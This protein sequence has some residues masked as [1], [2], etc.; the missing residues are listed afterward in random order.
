[1]AHQRFAY[2]SLGDVRS[3]A[4]QLGEDLPLSEQTDI[5]FQPLPLK[6]GITLKNRIALQPMEGSDGTADGAPGPLTER[7]YHRFAVGGAGLIWFEA[8]ATAPEVRASPHQLYLTEQNLSHFQRLV[9]QIKEIGLKENGFAPVVIMQA[10]HS[11]RYSK[12]EGVPAPIIAYNN[13][14]FEKD[15]PIDASRIVTDDALSAYAARYE[16]TARLCREAGFDGIDVKCCHRY[17]ANELLSAYQRPG[18]YG[19]S[20]ENRTRF[21]RECYQAAAA[22][23]GPGFLKTSRLNVY[24]GYPYPY[25]FGVS[26]EGGVA[27]V[28]EEGI[29]LGRLLQ[30]AFDIPLLNVTIG[31]PY[32]NPHVNRPYDSG[33]YV[34]P[35][36]PFTGLAR[37]MS[38][39][40]QMQAALDIPVVGSAFSYLR[41]FAPNLAAGMVEG[42]HAAVAGFGRMAFADPDFPKQLEDEGSIPAGA[43]CVT[44]GRCA[45]LLRAGGPSG[46][47][48]R[49]EAYRTT[50]TKE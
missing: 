16:Q 24:D 43:V 11:G 49:D 33:A 30:E 37:M 25:G 8:V 28:L 13:P 48:V 39:V 12:P 22:G 29:A 7:R 34:P 14:L 21:L 2:K 19:G 20:F 23:A 17:M 5:L 47:V 42:G 18:R 9:A 45:A 36:H 31:N 40:G 27:P 1:M 3:T 32:T 41:Q 26:P 38:C 44:C 4:Q 10:T 15:G 35:E 46:C 50:A 6:N